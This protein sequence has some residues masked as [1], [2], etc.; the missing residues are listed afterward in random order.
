MAEP[1]LQVQD[2]A[3]ETNG[4]QILD[5]IHLTIHPGELHVLMGRNGTG[6]STL[7][8]T[9]M[10]DPRYDVTRGQIVFQ[11]T[12]I[13]RET[14]DVRARAGIFLSFQTP[15][16]IPGVTLEDFIR[17]SRQTITGESMR[18]TRFHRELVAQM[19][20]LDMDPSYAE[21]YL[22]VGFSGGE[23]KKTEIL[24]LLM[25]NSKLALLDETDSGLDVDAVR[26][27]ATGIRKW[28]NEGNSLI[29]ITHNAKLIE[30]LPVTRVHVI[31]DKKIGR[32]GGP[33]LID[34]ITAAGFGALEEGH[35]YGNA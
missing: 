3:V 7:V 29:I 30:G 2:L 15:Q 9:I 35:T 17:T 1:L 22:N 8:S 32:S 18:V 23:K 12:D 27:V 4:Q 11:G 28:H 5:G 25:L 21:R 14:A 10:G 20:E 19:K 26:T 24:Q 33:E 6:K 13:T 34:E 31:E 16:E